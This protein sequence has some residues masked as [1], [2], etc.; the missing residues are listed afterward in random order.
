MRFIVMGH[1]ACLHS[2]VC[3]GEIIG[4]FHHGRLIFIAGDLP[5]KRAHVLRAVKSRGHFCDG[6]G[7]FDY[8]QLD[9]AD[10]AANTAHALL[11]RH[12]ACR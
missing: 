1:R 11:P 12:R 10:I 8:G 4:V 3:R 6:D 7:V 2:L 5:D 9:F